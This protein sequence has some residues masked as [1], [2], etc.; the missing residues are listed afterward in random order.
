MYSGQKGLAQEG[1]VGEKV[2]ELW[3]RKGLRR[4]LKET[5]PM[6]WQRLKK[7]SA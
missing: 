1:F 2:Q 3:Q 4:D 7:S 5:M 6:T